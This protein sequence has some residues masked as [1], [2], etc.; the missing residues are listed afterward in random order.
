[1]RPKLQNR[2]CTGTSIPHCCPTQRGVLLATE[3]PG[4]APRNGVW[5]L[6]QMI[7]WPTSCPGAG[8]RCCLSLAHWAPALQGGTLIRSPTSVQHV[9]QTCSFDTCPCGQGMHEFA[10][11]RLLRCVGRTSNSTRSCYHL[12]LSQ[13]SDSSAQ[14]LLAGLQHTTSRRAW[15]A[16]H[17][18]AL[19]SMCDGESASACA[20]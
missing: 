4:P 6:Q 20:T 15:Q 7:C 5:G 12:C 11:V 19:L 18:P 13:A 2:S 14:C 16:L 17:S 1:M 8:P 3:K 10:A 9:H